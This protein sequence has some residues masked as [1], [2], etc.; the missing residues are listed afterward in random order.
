[1]SSPGDSTQVTRL[2]DDFKHFIYSPRRSFSV[3]SKQDVVTKLDYGDD[4]TVHS[5]T[6]RQKLKKV[7]SNPVLGEHS[8]NLKQN[9]M[10]EVNGNCHLN[11]GILCFA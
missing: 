3:D 9:L 10:Q 2:L 11:V 4:T 6:V 5:T 7:R 1:M 8:L